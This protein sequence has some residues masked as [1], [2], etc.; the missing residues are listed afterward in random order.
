MLS[1]GDDWGLEGFIKMARGHHN[2][3]TWIHPYQAVV[4][5]TS[6]EDN[7]PEDPAA[8]FDPEEEITTQPP[9]EGEGLLIIC[10]LLEK[11]FPILYNC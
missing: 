10:Y 5:S 8:T 7:D 4:T 11:I 3:G 9:T 1:W 2:C 6:S